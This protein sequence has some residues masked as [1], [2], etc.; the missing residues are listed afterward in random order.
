MQRRPASDTIRSAMNRQFPGRYLWL[1][2]LVLTL[3]ACGVLM[4][5]VTVPLVALLIWSMD[6]LRAEWGRAAASEAQLAETLRSTTD[7]ETTRL[8]TSRRLE[9]QNAAL[10][11]QARNPV[12]RG[13]DLPAAFR[14]ITEVAARTLDTARVSIWLHHDDRSAIRSADLYEHPAGVHSDGVELRVGEFPRYFAALAENRAIAA[15]DARTDLRT[16]EF[17][18]SYLEPLGSPRCSTR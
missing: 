17:R 16:S 13:D 1:L 8:A 12:P 7:A 14:A 10:A 6:R 4:G 3:V 18:A 11:G 15:H 5:W 9:L 2:V